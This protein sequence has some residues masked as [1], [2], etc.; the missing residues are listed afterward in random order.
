MLFSETGTLDQMIIDHRVHLGKIPFLER[1]FLD[2]RKRS[3]YIETTESFN[4][5]KDQRVTGGTLPI[6]AFD[7]TV[8]PPS[9]RS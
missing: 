6:D 2:N 1:I 8:L 3:C 9:L 4:T 7:S 5:H